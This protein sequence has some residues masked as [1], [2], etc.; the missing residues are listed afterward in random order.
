LGVG[1]KRATRSDVSAQRNWQKENPIAKEIVNCKDTKT[2]HA[3][4]KNRHG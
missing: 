1:K 3:R 2:R 4:S